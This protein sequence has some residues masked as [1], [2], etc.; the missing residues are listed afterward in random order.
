MTDPGHVFVVHSDLTHLSCDAWLLPTDGALNVTE[1]WTRGRHGPALRAHV[2]ELRA[3]GRRPDPVLAVP[4]W[5]T[6]LPLPILTAVPMQGTDDPVELADRARAALHEAHRALAGRAPRNGRQRTLFALGA[7]GTGSGGAGGNRG[8][9]VWALVRALQP[10]ADELGMDLALVLYRRGDYLAAQ[11]ARR[12]QAGAG[13]GLPAELQ[14]KARLLGVRAAKGEVI[15]FLG[16]GVSAGAGLPSWTDLIKDL[17]TT[18]DLGAAAR[19]D[20]DRLGV[21]D[22]AQVIRSLLPAGTTLGGEVAART[23]GSGLHAVSHAL[24]ASLPGRE[25]VTLNYDD[26]Y[27]RAVADTGQRVAV[28]PEAGGRDADRWLLKLHGTTTD[29]ASIVLTRQDYLRYSRGRSTLSAVVQTLL[30]T[31]HLLFLGFGL[32]D[33]HV[34]AIMDDVRQ[35]LPVDHSGRLGTALMLSDQ[36]LQ[37]HLWGTELDLVSLGGN[38]VAEGARRLELFLDLLLSE[39]VQDQLPLMDEHY[40]GVLT[41]GERALREHVRTFVDGLPDD[42]RRTAAFTQLNTVIDG[43]HTPLQP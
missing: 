40:D 43:W 5:D 35:A 7:F 41:D 4:G 17:A 11:A 27:E 34:H 30:L 3:E 20:F 10:T 39:A 29:A 15:P 12:G 21:L 37:Q 42:A 1:L 9:V 33:D 19:A 13:G 16:A 23:T 31:R 38:G 36:P 2:E 18:I 8:A 22:Q 24:L 32:S 26:L 28:L 14:G 25:A 6:A